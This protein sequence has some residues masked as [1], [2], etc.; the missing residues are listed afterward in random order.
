MFATHNFMLTTTL[1]FASKPTCLPFQDTEYISLSFIRT[2]TH[3]ETGRHSVWEGRVQTKQVP[4][5]HQGTQFQMGQKIQTLEQNNGSLSKLYK[6]DINKLWLTQ[7]VS[8]GWDDEWAK[9]GGGESE[10]ICRERCLWQQQG[11]HSVTI[12]RGKEGKRLMVLIKGLRRS[13]CYIWH[14]SRQSTQDHI[15]AQEQNVSV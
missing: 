2:V 8:Q 12:G 1:E 10:R 7:Y 5:C 11:L 13:P 9:A 6:N 4:A 14:L 3:R 15:Y